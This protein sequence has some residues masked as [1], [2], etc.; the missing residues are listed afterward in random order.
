MQA[1]FNYFHS[2]PCGF[3]LPNR[4]YCALPYR[5]DIN[6]NS[7][8]LIMIRSVDRSPQAFQLQSRVEA[9]AVDSARC[10]RRRAIRM[11]TAALVLLCGASLW[12]RLR[13]IEGTLPYP[14]FVDEVFVAAPAARMLTTG[15]LNPH[16]FNYPSLPMYLTAVGMAGGFLR[17][18][19]HHEIQDI[20]NLGNV[21]YPYYDT[22]GAVQGA[23]QLFSLLSV[24]ALAAAGLVA[25]VALKTPAAIF[26]APLFLEVSPLFFS[27]SWTYLNVDIVGTCFVVL[28]LV[29][30]LKGIKE[31]S[32]YQSAV[33]AGVFA[34]LATASKYTLA[35]VIVPVLLAIWFY[36]DARRRISAS[37]ATLG[38]MLAA[39]LIVVPYSVLDIPGF[40]NGLAYEAYHYSHGHHGYDAD[41]GLPQLYYYAGQFVAEFGAGGAALAILG[42]C[43]FSLADWRRALVLLS[44]PIALLWLLAAQRVHFGRDILSLFP[45]ASLFLAFGVVSVYGWT[46][47]LA[48]GRRW[49]EGGL[50]RPVSVVVGL[51]LIA[52]AMPFGHITDQLRGR[53]DSRNLAQAWIQAHFPMEWSIIVPKQ[54]CVDIRDLKAKGRR[55]T[56]VDLNSAGDAEILHKLLIESPVPAVIMVPRWDAHFRFPGWDIAEILSNVTSHWRIVKTFGSHPVN[57]EPPVIPLGDPAFAVAI[58]EHAKP[59]TEVAPP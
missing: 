2:Y 22:P 59:R 56:V 43:V 26:F 17:S 6:D 48:S 42:A 52:I 19:R 44:F 20:A 49:T 57:V 5:F 15:K 30:C 13:N 18:A 37:V 50:R 24:V 53:T 27:Q 16:Y 28:A 41:P 58:L 55:V 40:L 33:L 14:L 12:L 36:F 54:L 45:I 23:R 1:R 9:A 32:M 10:N 25:Y 4:F 31:L 51:V 47:K 8:S 34:G 3:T 29:A 35:L 21:R 39:F 38:A 46:L 7:D 11:W